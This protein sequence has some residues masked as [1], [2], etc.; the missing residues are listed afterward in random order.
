MKKKFKSN[1]IDFYD[2]IYK[3]SKKYI[4]I[5]NSSTNKFTNNFK[6]INNHTCSI[7]YLS[8]L[9]DG[10]LVSCSADNCLNIYKNNSFDLQLS[11]K[12]HSNGVCSFSELNDG[13]IITFSCDNTMKIIKLINENKY[14]VEQEL[15]EHSNEV[16]KV[17]EIK[18]NELIS[19][20][21]D[22]TMKIWNRNDENNF[23]CIKT[24]NYQNSN[25][26]CNILKLNDN[27]FVTSSNGD[28]NI[29]FWNIENYSNISTIDNIESSYA[30]NY[31][32]LI[33]D[34]VLCVGGGNSKGF[35]LITISNHQLIKNIIG[36]KEIW[37]I[38]KCFDGLILCSIVDDEDNHNLVKYQYDNFN[39]IKKVEKIKA[40]NQK[41]H[42]CIE[43]NNGEIASGGSD[44]LIKL[45]RD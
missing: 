20:S 36:P 24:I 11:I 31:L 41:I 27:E 22:N 3:K 38:S 37:S 28:K 19:I 39:L 21:L 44:N 14:Q 5:F 25:S 17:I 45:W 18:E 7:Y 9:K 42:S 23:I 2:K 15:K 8:Q 40:H 12:E 13:R 16:Y 26:C 6:T 29:K 4:S 1:K 34:D 30:F 35:Y 32:C 33:D 43:L 10:R